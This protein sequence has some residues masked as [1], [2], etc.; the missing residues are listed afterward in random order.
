MVHREINKASHAKES[1]RRGVLKPKAID[2]FQQSDVE[3][4]FV[5]Y[6]VQ[7]RSSYSLY[8]NLGLKQ[9]LRCYAPTTMHG[10]IL[11]FKT[12][13]IDFQRKAVAQVCLILHF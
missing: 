13:V 10:S 7:A 9:Q 12:I 5:T 2:Y 8:H 11:L 3:V 4:S 1:L 6:P